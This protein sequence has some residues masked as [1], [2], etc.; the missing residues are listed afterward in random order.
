ME[1]KQNFE[2]KNGEL[3]PTNKFNYI[4]RRLADLSSLPELKETLPF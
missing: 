1:M 2:F 3:S 4:K